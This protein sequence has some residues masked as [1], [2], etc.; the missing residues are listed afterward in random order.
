MF[1]TTGDYSTYGKA[2][3]A[4]ALNAIDDFNEYLRSIDREEMSLIPESVYLSTNP[5]YTLEQVKKLHA[6]GV[7]VFI[8]PET[9]A[10][11][12][13]I[14]PFVDSEELLVISTSSTA[15]SLAVADSIYRLVPDDTH[16][17]KLISILAEE[18]DITTVFLLVRDD[19]WGNGLAD[20]IKESFSGN[21]FTD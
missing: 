3:H 9:S 12:A 18:R 8:G 5:E 14:K 6:D 16:Q 7:D 2:S 13:M 1:S 21:N 10:E 17:G 15:P 20:A 19:I 4:A 11:L